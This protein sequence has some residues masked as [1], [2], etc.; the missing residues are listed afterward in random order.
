[1]LH[2]FAQVV[3][4]AQLHSHHIITH[5]FE[6]TEQKWERMDSYINVFHVC[7]TLLFCI[8]STAHFHSLRNA[9]F[10]CHNDLSFQQTKFYF[11]CIAHFPL[12][13]YPNSLCVFVTH[14]LPFPL[15]FLSFCT[16]FRFTFFTWYVHFVLS[17]WRFWTYKVNNFGYTNWIKLDGNIKK[18]RLSIASKSNN[19]FVMTGTMTYFLIYIRSFYKT[20]E[21]L[22]RTELEKNSVEWKIWHWIVR[23]NSNKKKF[24]M[25]AQIGSHNWRKKHHHIW[26]HVMYWNIFC[27]EI[28]FFGSIKQK[29]VTGN[30]TMTPVLRLIPSS[31]TQDA[32]LNSL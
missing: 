8:T 24:C 2:R 23:M 15:L 26:Q 14:F 13:F 28:K 9:V 30:F 21:Y 1:M 17:L 7:Y 12:K 27:Y 29:I 25:C 5:W 11:N 4:L 32:S 22:H 20:G 6:T 10:F 19:V 3:L 16:Q 31:H 18:N